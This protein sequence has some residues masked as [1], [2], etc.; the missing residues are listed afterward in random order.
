MRTLI[1]GFGVTGQA[2]F[3]FLKS[4]SEDIIV[5]D[6]KPNGLNNSILGI[7]EALQK[8][9]DRVLLSP[10]IPPTHEWVKKAESLDIPIISEIELGILYC[11]SQKLIGITGTNGKTTVTL[12][13][14]HIL[15]KLGIRAK[16]VGNVGTPFLDYMGLEDVDVLVVE[17]SSYQIEKTYTRA[18]DAA[19]LL[20]ISPDHLDRYPDMDAYAYEK[21][22]LGHLVNV[23]CPFFMNFETLH[24]FPN[25]FHFDHIQT[26]GW[27]KEA[28]YLLSKEHFLYKNVEYILP[29]SYRDMGRYGVENVVVAYCLCSTLGLSAD[30]FFS[31]LVSFQKPEHRMEYVATINQVNYY[32]DSKGTNIEAVMRGVESLKGSVILIAGGVDKGFP[33]TSWASVFRNKVSHVY[34]FG[35]AADKIESDLNAQIPVTKMSSLEEAVIEAKVNAK[36]GMNVLLS[37]GC[38]SFD[39]FE[40]YIERGN[41]FKAIVKQT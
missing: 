23:E 28:D 2:A 31:A 9:P 1:L 26:F 18:F 37:P 30:D 3:R 34:A 40:N 11:K 22:R 6:S 15:N 21:S 29:L 32:N 13:V 12:M 5:C 16:S 25:I 10:G 35:Q 17:L 27:Q 8:K 19:A 14:E 38:S 24:Q 39:M 33:Y 41:A 20:N 4:K 36:P 7:D